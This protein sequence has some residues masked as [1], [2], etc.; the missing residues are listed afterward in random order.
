[1]TGL[2]KSEFRKFMSTR[3]WWILLAVMVAYMAFMAAALAAMYIAQGTITAGSSDSGEINLDPK[4]APSIVYTVAASFGYIFPALIGVMSFTG[5]FR[6]KTIT[7]TFIA[8]PNRTNVLVA[9]LLSGI[10]LGVV[11][12]ALGTLGCVAAGAAVLAIGDIPTQLGTGYAWEIIGRSVLALTLWLLFGVAL[13]SVVTNQ[14]V[15]VVILIAFTQVVEPLLRMILGAWGPTEGIS[16][17]LP[18]AVGDSIAGGSLYNAIIPAGPLGFW[19]ALLVMVAYIAAL[20]II[21]RFTTL[22]R[23]VG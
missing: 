17:F 6:H 22:K 16:R 11:Y 21:G 14:T 5:E 15:A 4:L 2:V 9:K 18:G 8:S 19:P 1:M 10:P 20:A 12:G 3:M 23:D 7:P 13:G